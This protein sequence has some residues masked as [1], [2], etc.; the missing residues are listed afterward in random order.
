MGVVAVFSPLCNHGD[1]WHIVY[2]ASVPESKEPFLLPR[3]TLL[4]TAEE[5]ENPAGGHV[6]AGS[7]RRNPSTKLQAACIFFSLFF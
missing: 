3:T 7:R 5:A 2:V 6:T 1:I 4:Q